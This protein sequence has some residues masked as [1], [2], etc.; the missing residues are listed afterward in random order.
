MP[1]LVEPDLV[2]PVVARWTL[3][4]HGH[5]C[6]RCETEIPAGVPCRYVSRQNWPYCARC[7]LSLLY[8]TA[9]AVEVLWARDM[10][11]RVPAGHLPLTA[12]ERGDER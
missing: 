12:V 9:P 7:V 1:E 11:S 3:L 6:R 10:P 2:A 5:P 8:E 4:R